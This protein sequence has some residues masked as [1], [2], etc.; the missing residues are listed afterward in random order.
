MKRIKKIKILIIDDHKM[1]RDGLRVMLEMQKKK[2][3]FVI[4]EA[5]NGE[6]GVEKAIR[7][8][9]D[10]IL[11]DYQLTDMDGAKSAQI[12]MQKKPE[13][14]ILALSNYNEYAYIDKMINTAKV[15]GYILKNIEPEELIRAIETVLGNK[16]YYSNDIALNLLSVG[17]TTS[18]YSQTKNAQKIKDENLSKREIEILKLIADEYTNEEIANKLSLSKRTVDTHRQNIMVKLNVRNAIGLTKAALELLS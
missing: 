13:S 3:T 10:I 1:I 17:R 16:S 9:Y 7:N 2:Y 18:N 15:K 12:I 6:E 5:E 8:S 14:K 4:D 11:T